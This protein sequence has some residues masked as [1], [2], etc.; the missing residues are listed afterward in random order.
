MNVYVVDAG[1]YIYTDV[2]DSELGG[3]T[4]DDYA[5]RI[6]AADTRGQAKTVFLNYDKDWRRSFDF[7]GLRVLLLEKNVDIDTPHVM[8][9]DETSYP[10]DTDYWELAY[11]KLDEV[12]HGT[13]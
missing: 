2:I 1:P 11:D 3:P 9:Y 6:V 5:I 10:Y 4:V 8:E 12:K 7:I 13:P